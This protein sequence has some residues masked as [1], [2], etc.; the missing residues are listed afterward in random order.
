MATL[1]NIL[2]EIKNVP[3]NR[4]EELY[5]LINSLSPKTKQPDGKRKEIL[6]F[7]GAF[8]DMSETDYADFL[9]YTKSLRA[10]L[11]DRKFK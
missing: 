4:L 10:Q 3:A 2:K 8:S 1:N 5:Q 7:A 9:N 11:F 6:S